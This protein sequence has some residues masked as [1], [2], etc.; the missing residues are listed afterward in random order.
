[1]AARRGGREEDEVEFDDSSNWDGVGNK[2]VVLGLLEAVRP[3]RLGLQ[4]ARPS[5]SK[6]SAG[7]CPSA[8]PGKPGDFCLQDGMQLGSLSGTA[9]QAWTFVN[10]FADRLVDLAMD[11]APDTVSRPVVKRY[12]LSNSRKLAC[13][14][15]EPSNSV[16]N[17]QRTL[18]ASPHLFNARCMLL[19]RVLCVCATLCVDNVLTHS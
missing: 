19:G 5:L 14:P 17:L 16:C 10:S 7:N 9:R 18:P 4:D 12:S 2:M 1:M 8:V 13:Q 6:Q 11:F 15:S 3:D